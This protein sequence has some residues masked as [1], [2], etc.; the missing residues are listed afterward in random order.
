[1]QNHCI[2]ANKTAG[3]TLARKFSICRIF[4]FIASFPVRRV[5]PFYLKLSQVHKEVNMAD[6]PKNIEEKYN[7]FLN[8]WTTLA[9]DKT[10]GGVTL[11]EFSAQVGKSNSPRQRLVEL[12]D[13]R[14][15]E[16]TKR[17]NEDK[18]SLKLCERVKNGVIADPDFGDDSALYEAFGFVRKSER[19]SG[20]TRKK[21]EIDQD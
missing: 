10:F 11:A 9:P 2:E 5:F 19:Q 17:D 3:S 1:M 4:C 16:E 18:N 21:A 15:A 13:E 20:L 8:A 7:R 6:S 12:D 14:T